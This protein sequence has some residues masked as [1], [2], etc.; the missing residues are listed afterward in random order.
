MQQNIIT[1]IYLK[2]MCFH[3]IRRAMTD[4]P[5]C[6]LWRSTMAPE[7]TILIKSLMDLYYK[8]PYQ[9]GYT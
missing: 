5:L 1:N 9:L 4:D 6:E 8:K 2:R 7:M 3:T